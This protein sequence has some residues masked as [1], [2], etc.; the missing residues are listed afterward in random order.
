MLERLRRKAYQVIQVIF[1][2]AIQ[3]WKLFKYFLRNNMV[4]L[5]FWLR[6]N[7][8]IHSPAMRTDE[9]LRINPICSICTIV[10]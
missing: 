10:V 1:I 3:Y 5:M 2:Y 4:R 9:S 7:F 6:T 8:A